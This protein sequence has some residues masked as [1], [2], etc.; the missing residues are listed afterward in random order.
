MKKY[1]CSQYSSSLITKYD[2]VHPMAVS[3]NYASSVMLIILK[4]PIHYVFPVTN[5][6]VI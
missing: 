4:K 2:A 3:K 6:L 5:L 1:M